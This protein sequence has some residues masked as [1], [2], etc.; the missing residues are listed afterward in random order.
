MRHKTLA[1]TLVLALLL[2]CFQA[3]AADNDQ[4]MN[5]KKL[6]QLTK[7]LDPEP[8]GKPGFRTF[9]IGGYTV[10]VITDERA[11]RMR[12]IV[13]IAD[14]AN[15]TSGQM[16]RMLQANFDTSL[17]ARYTIAE[18]TVWAAFI[19]PLSPLSAHEFVSGIAQIV[20]LAT[21]YG[22]TYSSGAMRFKGGDSEDLL[23]DAYDKLMKKGH[24]VTL[25]L[26]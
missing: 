26:F 14:I 24:K 18:D 19:H 10:T 2:G 11:D 7:R 8:K 3:R 15:L 5:N 22:T 21:S 17:D 16:L 1:G 12:I 9:K 6:D 23:R 4:T 13:P 20:N 25:D